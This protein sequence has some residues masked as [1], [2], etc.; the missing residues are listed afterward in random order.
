MIKNTYL[1][2]IENQGIYKFS[3]YL[4]DRKQ[5]LLVNKYKAF[6]KPIIKNRQR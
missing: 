1:L 4:L 3:L 5:S 2:I 6:S